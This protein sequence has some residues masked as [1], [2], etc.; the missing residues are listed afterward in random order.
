MLEELKTN[1]LQVGLIPAPEQK[2]HT[3][4]IRC[5]YSHNPEWY[6]ELYHICGR[7]S[8]KRIVAAMNGIV[9]G[10]SDGEQWMKNRII[11][12]SKDLKHD[13]KHYENK[14]YEKSSLSF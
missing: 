4:M 5:A 6:G 2:H 14:Y 8:R 3:H 12:Y 11:Q 9:N 10:S 7:A 13:E 1:S